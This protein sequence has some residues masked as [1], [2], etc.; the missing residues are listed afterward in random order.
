[1]MCKCTGSCFSVN[2]EGCK[3]ICLSGQ[4]HKQSKGGQCQYKL[5]RCTFENPACTQVCLLQHSLSATFV[6]SMVMAGDRHIDMKGLLLDFCSCCYHATTMDYSSLPPA[7]SSRRRKSH[8]CSCCAVQRCIIGHRSSPIFISLFCP[9]KQTG[10]RCGSSAVQCC[11]CLP[12]MI[13]LLILLLFFFFS[14]TQPLS[15]TSRL[16]TTENKQ[17]THYYH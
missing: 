4:T 5:H 15:K 12:S 11:G 14:P 10:S 3:G 1:M 2:L 13:P 7:A 16:L 6:T 9:I 8:P 17:A